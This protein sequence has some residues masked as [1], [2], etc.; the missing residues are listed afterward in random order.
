MSGLQKQRGNIKSPFEVL[1]LSLS[2]FFFFQATANVS[3]GTLIAV[4]A[5]VEEKERARRP[6][7]RPRDAWID[8]TDGFLSWQM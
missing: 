6:S 8:Q 5:S 7:S 3:T 1:L 4:Q 2:F